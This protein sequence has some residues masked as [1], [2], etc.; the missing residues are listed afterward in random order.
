MFIGAIW[1]Q[2]P[3][4]TVVIVTNRFHTRRAQWI[5]KTLHPEKFAQIS[6]VGA[7]SDG[8]EWNYWWMSEAGLRW[9]TSEYLK[10]AYYWIVYSTVWQRAKVLLLCF[11][12]LVAVVLAIATYRRYVS[13]RESPLSVDAEA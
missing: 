11:V 12:T 3:D 5:A 13:R 7:P 1:D 8:F 6:F 10:L 9:V 2:Q 4:A